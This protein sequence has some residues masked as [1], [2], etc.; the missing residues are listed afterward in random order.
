MTSK[1][2]KIPQLPRIR[3]SGW[4]L[5]TGIWL[6]RSLFKEY[7]I[8]PS[9]LNQAEKCCSCG[10]SWRSLFLSFG[11]AFQSTT[12]QISKRLSGSFQGRQTV[13]NLSARLL[14]GSPRISLEPGVLSLELDVS[15]S[16]LTTPT[17]SSALMT[18]GSIN[19]QTYTLQFRRPFRQS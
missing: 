12:W 10:P 3:T 9:S 18:Q 17:Q 7:S 14:R 19:L 16:R 4:S 8:R 13:S 15:N 2:F 6:H 1:S 5:L 11:R